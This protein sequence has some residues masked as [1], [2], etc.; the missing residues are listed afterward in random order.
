[1][2]S[3]QDALTLRRLQE[4]ELLHSPIRPEKLPKAVLQDDGEM[5]REMVIDELLA[6]GDDAQIL[7]LRERQ[8]QMIK[9]RKIT[10]E[11]LNR[12]QTILLHYLMEKDR[13][14]EE[15]KSHVAKLQPPDPESGLDE[16]TLKKQKK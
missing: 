15:Y 3:F 13:G 2:A 4:A 16:K 6:A 5:I 11:Q 12:V 1:M 10:H 9:D 8:F 14:S 7:A